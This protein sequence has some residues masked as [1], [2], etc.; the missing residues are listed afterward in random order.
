MRRLRNLSLSKPPSLTTFDACPKPFSSQS[1]LE[2]EIP[3]FFKERETQPR[4]HAM[5]DPIFADEALSSL[6]AE[7][8]TSDILEYIAKSTFEAA[9]SCD[10]DAR[11]RL[12]NQAEVIRCAA[13]VCQVLGN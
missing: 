7:H 5:M 13:R 3:S 11:S 4:G 6:L 12:K 2:G 10:G 1:R 9:T 8:P